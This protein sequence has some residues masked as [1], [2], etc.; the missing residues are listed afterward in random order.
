MKGIKINFKVIQKLDQKVL[1]DKE[2]RIRVFWKKKQNLV[3]NTLP[4]IETA[5]RQGMHI[6][7]GYYGITA[8]IGKERLLLP[9]E[10]HYL[11]K[12][13]KNLQR[14]IEKLLEPKELTYRQ[15]NFIF[16]E[17]KKSQEKIEKSTNEFKLKAKKR[18]SNIIL[19][20][21]GKK[22]I[23]IE[24]G[25]TTVDLLERLGEIEEITQAV[26]LRTR[27][28]IDEKLRAEK[29][30]LIIYKRLAK[31][32]KEIR[33]GATEERIERIVKE[34]S[35]GKVNLL[36]GLDSIKVQP[37][38]KRIKSAQIQRLKKLFQYFEQER[39]DKIC[40]TLENAFKK[41]RPVILERESRK[42]KKIKMKNIIT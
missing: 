26:I 19:S 40:I 23:A 10:V 14:I 1:V 35:Q 22:E 3:E 38:L 6:I 21:K 39:R 33:E 15:F 12:L 30:F 9:G 31:F 5:I 42:I 34:I 36:A 37:Y 16:S 32:I 2:G 11:N 28:L 7:E 18:L 8:N 29:I 24:S 41:L 17:F 20:K 13:I 4:D 25:K 27:K